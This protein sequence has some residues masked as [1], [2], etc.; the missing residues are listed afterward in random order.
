MLQRTVQAHKGKLAPRSRLVWTYS[1]SDQLLNCLVPA[2][3][4][5]GF[6]FGQ[7]IGRACDYPFAGWKLLRL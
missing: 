7:W 4:F 2:N 6:I 1:S 3:Y 5:F